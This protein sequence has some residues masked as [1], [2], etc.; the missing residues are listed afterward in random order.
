[1]KQ[2]G[3]ILVIVLLIGAGLI[4]FITRQE[5]PPPKSVQSEAPSFS[6]ADAGGRTVSSGDLKGKVL[7]VH[8]WAPW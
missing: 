7:F 8:F 4:F 6:V 5:Q 1:M 2:K 3:I